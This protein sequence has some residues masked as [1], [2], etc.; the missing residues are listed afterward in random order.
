MSTAVGSVGR[1]FLEDTVL[2]TNLEAAREVVRQ[3]RYPASAASSS[4]ISSTWPAMRTESRFWPPA[5]LTKDCTKTYVVELSPLG[6]VEMTR[7]NA[8]GWHS[9]YRGPV[10]VRCGAR[11]VVSAERGFPSRARLRVLAISSVPSWLRF[12]RCGRVFTA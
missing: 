8:A 7:Q 9:R 5:E 2:R 3:L 11:W 1:P 12:I 10:P 6:L 4:L